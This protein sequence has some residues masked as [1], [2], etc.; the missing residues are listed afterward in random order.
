MK[1]I[2]K[3][4]IIALSV[5]SIL[6]CNVQAEELKNEQYKNGYD[7][8]NDPTLNLVIV[9]KDNNPLSAQKGIP[10]QNGSPIT[11]NN[12]VHIKYAKNNKMDFLYGGGC[13]HWDES[14]NANCY[15]NNTSIVMDA[16]NVYSLT[17][18]YASGL[19]EATA[20]GNIF[21]N[22]DSIV[23]F[24][25]GAEASGYTN[26]SAHATGNVYVNDSAIVKH[27]VGATSNS[28]SNAT[29]I[30]NIYINDNTKLNETSNATGSHAY[31]HGLYEST[32]LNAIAVGNVYFNNSEVTDGAI[33]AMADV[34]TFNP[35]Q[36][37]HAT[38]IGNIYINNTTTNIRQNHASSDIYAAI[39]YI[40][41][42]DGIPNSYK[43]YAVAKGNVYLNNIM[44][45]GNIIGASAVARSNF[46]ANML[47]EGNVY[48]NNNTIFGGMIYAT[49]IGD[50]PYTGNILNSI[51]TAK[52]SVTIYGNSKFQFID[53]DGT[54]V[55]ETEVW[56]SFLNNIPTYYQIFNGNTFSMG[57][58]PINVAKLGNF[59]HYDFYL[60]DYNKDAIANGTALVTVTQSIQNDNTVTN[61]NGVA[62]TTTNKSNIQINGISGE[63]ITKVGDKIT[64]IDASG[65]DV[66]FIGGDNGQNSDNTSNL[67]GLFNTP[68][69]NTVDVGLVAKADISYS[70]NSDN[71]ITATV[72][73]I[74]MDNGNVT[75]NVKPLAE[76]RLGGL[77]NTVRGADLLLS[78]F[79]DNGIAVGS[80][81]PIAVIDGGVSKY[82]SGSHVDSRDYRIMIGSRY[83]IFDNLATGLTVEY[84]R[85]NYDTHNDFNDK[86][87]KGD[88]HSYNYGVSLFG[89]YQH[90]LSVGYAYSDAALRFGRTSTEFNSGDIIT[91]SGKAAYYKSKV[92][93]IGGLVG[94][95]YVYP[96]TST[97]SFDSSIHYFYT[98]L[99]SDSVVIDGDT[100]HFGKSTSSRVQLKEQY[101]Y[102]TVDAIVLSL[103]GIY[104]YEFDSDAKTNVSGIS[105]NAPSVQGSTG[106]M[107]LGIKAT[108]LE[109]NKDFSV[110]LNVRGYSGKR[111]G[112]SISALIK[113]DF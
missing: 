44:L 104:E 42:Q 61:Q 95:G 5:A 57:A 12:V 36:T 111:D 93:Y 94:A 66:T 89:Q 41:D 6:S 100:V 53:D 113:Y 84:G 27:I 85:S 50:N 11:Q 22:N 67:A 79:N 19:N 59:E 2:L 78:T 76:A 91:G 40:Y 52:G 49:E 35:N 87:V 82:H 38:A 90:E 65:N 72:N 103:A 7:L 24:V 37:A 81:S 101:N 23:D 46:E 54:L 15:V 96:A 107:E 32:D 58:N 62:V 28:D 80:F 10:Y 18:A 71:T 112:A 34:I 83:Q 74:R 31:V 1:M 3:K 108:P 16:G 21:I 110:N 8:I 106:I 102:Q 51:A 63:G 70:V 25:I 105:I 43:S 14:P 55:Q 9:D 69:N 4:T 73:N 13:Q 92:N 33:G 68:T 26:T 17:G 97:S 47:V 39:T 48:L 98:R 45:T 29:A 60:N 64:L 75:T 30:G 99:G 20:T 86:T 88:G 77:Q 56:G 109:D